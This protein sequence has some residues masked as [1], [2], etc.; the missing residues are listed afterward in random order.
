M[1]LV[2]VDHMVRFLIVA[3]VFINEVDKNGFQSTMEVI[4][5]LLTS[6]IVFESFYT[7]QPS[8]NFFAIIDIQ[9]NI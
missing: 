5:K 9:F 1:H 3:N 7:Y 8:G 4:C 6:F 2:S